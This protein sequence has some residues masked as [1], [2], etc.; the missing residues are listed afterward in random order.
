MARANEMAHFMKDIALAGAALLYAVCAR[1][2]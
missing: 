1:G 2:A